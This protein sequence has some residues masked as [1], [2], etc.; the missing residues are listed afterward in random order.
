MYHDI[1]LFV[2]HAADIA[3]A[4]KAQCSSLYWADCIRE[5]FFAQGDRERELGLPVSPLCDRETVIWHD[6]QIGFVKFVIRPA[7]ELLGKIIP[8][9]EDD[10]L[11]SID[12]TLKYWEHEKLIDE[13]L[14]EDGQ[15]A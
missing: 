2:L 6:S 1:I 14:T 10:I 13:N 3:N 4:G 15:C 7:F 8:K 11:P 5:E 9:V 12:N